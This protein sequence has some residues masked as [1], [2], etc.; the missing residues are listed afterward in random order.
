MPTNHHYDFDLIVIGSGAG[1]GVAAHIAANEGR[2][3]AIVEQESI[4]G[5]CPTYG[6]IPTKALLHSAQI[7]DEAKNGD[8]GSQAE[9]APTVCAADVGTVQPVL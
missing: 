8:Q 6:C 4:G 1:G 3:V 5:E 7:Y 2:N 9:P